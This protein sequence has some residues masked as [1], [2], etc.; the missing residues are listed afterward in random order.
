MIMLGLFG[1]LST[2]NYRWGYFGVSCAFFFVVLWGLFFPA[3]KGVRA[4]G[5]QVCANVHC[6]CMNLFPPS[7]LSLHTCEVSS[8]SQWCSNHLTQKRLESKTE[9]SLLFQSKDTPLKEETFSVKCR[10]SVTRY[11]LQ[12]LV[13]VAFI[14]FLDHSRLKANLLL[15]MLSRNCQ[16][17]AVMPQCLLSSRVKPCDILF[18]PAL[19]GRFLLV[20]FAL[21]S[22]SQSFIALL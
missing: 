4:R 10:A 6:T 5:G 12:A 20:S 15:L 11:A 19:S 21:F 17:T 9:P 2:N 18:L 8:C 13:A 7:P 22:S 1:A 3:A 16:R 14:P